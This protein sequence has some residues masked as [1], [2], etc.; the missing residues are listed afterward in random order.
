M[1]DELK[2]IKK[3][4][5]VLFKE[6]YQSAKERRVK[7]YIFRPSERVRWVVVGKTREYIVLPSVGYCS[8]ED[9]FFRVMDHAKPMCYHVLAAKI[10]ELTDMYEVIEESD[11]WYWRL[12][13]EWMPIERQT[14]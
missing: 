4:Y 11:E 5:P 7:K 12:M 6:A 10:A 1:N 3:K 9:F 2:K 8:C 14:V 13:S